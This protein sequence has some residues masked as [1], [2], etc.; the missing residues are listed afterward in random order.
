[1]I[2]V[3]NWDTK[4]SRDIFDWIACMFSPQEWRETCLLRAAQHGQKT[5]KRVMLYVH[6]FS[7]LLLVP[8]SLQFV[9]LICLPC[10]YVQGLRNN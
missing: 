6:I 3:D 9:F 4:T 2:I 7:F 5:K 8:W 1:M 10:I